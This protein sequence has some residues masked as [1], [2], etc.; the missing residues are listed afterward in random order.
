M[1]AP[2]HLPLARPN[3]MFHPTEEGET[4]IVTEKCDGTNFRCGCELKEN[5]N[6]NLS[7][8]IKSGKIPVLTMHSQ[9]SSKSFLWPMQNFIPTGFPPESSLNFSF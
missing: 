8:E 7:I 4:V 2:T 1:L 3:L 9:R 5:E 6:G